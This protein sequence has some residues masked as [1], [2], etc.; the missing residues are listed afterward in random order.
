MPVIRVS[1]INAKRISK[2]LGV[3]S[4]L[5]RGLYLPDSKPLRPFLNLPVPTVE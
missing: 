3:L 2:G 1:F 4:L 5:I